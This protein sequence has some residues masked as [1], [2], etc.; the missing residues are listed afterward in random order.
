MASLVLSRRENPFLVPLAFVRSQSYQKSTVKFRLVRL[1]LFIVLN[2]ILGWIV[3]ETWSFRFQTLG[4][5]P[6]C[7]PAALWSIHSLTAGTLI[8]LDK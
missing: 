2:V 8:V 5:V 4:Q 1:V 6:D 7:Q 3:L